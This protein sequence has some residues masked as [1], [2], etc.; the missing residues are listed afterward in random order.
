MRQNN[1][2]FN[3]CTSTTNASNNNHDKRKFVFALTNARSVWNKIPSLVDHMLELE[4][5][6]AIVTETWLHSGERL[7]K[8]KTD[9]K[10]EHA[11]ETLDRMR[12]K[13]GTNN[14]GG[15]VSIFYDV[16]RASFKEYRV[17]REG[18][19]FIEAR[20]KIQNNTRP[21]YVIATYLRKPR[22]KQSTH[23]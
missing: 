18:F 23:A 1:D 20:G 5:A 16:R 17:K 8:L 11:I 22:P 12:K 10:Q 9:L 6:F 3:K 21:M 13:R 7:E 2:R 4:A 19:E 14:P 15:G